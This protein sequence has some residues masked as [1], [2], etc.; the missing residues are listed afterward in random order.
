MKITTFNVQGMNQKSKQKL[1]ADD[2][3]KNNLFCLL[4]QETKIQQVDSLELKSSSNKSYTIYNSGHKTK[5]GKGIGRI[6]Q[7]N[8][9]LDFRAVSERIC[10]AKISNGKEKVLVISACSNQTKPKRIQK[11][12]IDS[13]IN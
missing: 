9:K 4:I 12:L 5:S 2:F 1:L 8:T 13:T 7:T 11:T 10:L 6:L 3:E